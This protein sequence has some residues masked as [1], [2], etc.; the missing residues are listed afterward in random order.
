MWGPMFTGIITDIGIIEKILGGSDKSFAIKTDFDLSK[1]TLG[2]SI[3]CSGVC[4]TVTSKEDNL[5][6]FDVSN[7]TLSKTTLDHWV[8]GTKLN[9]EKALC[10]GDQLGGHNVSGHVDCTAEITHMEKDARS[11]V[12]TIKPP[13]EFISF[14]APKGSVAI[15]GTSLTINKTSCDSIFL[16][17][18]PHTWENTIISDYRIGDLVNLEVD[19]MARYI[20][21]YV[22]HFHNTL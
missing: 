1:V 3:A 17:I 13:E 14:L 15:D 6:H 16:N 9:L 11:W 7:E 8:V 10:A 20:A 22:K 12:I 4:L 2:D 18:I 21:H 19:T 5:L